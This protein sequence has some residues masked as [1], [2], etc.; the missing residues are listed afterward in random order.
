MMSE[1]IVGMRFGDSFSVYGDYDKS[2]VIM[3]MGL[4]FGFTG[5]VCC[6]IS[7]EVPFFLTLY[8]FVYVFKPSSQTIWSPCV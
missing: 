8:T 5:L 4:S 3:F 6:G 2:D 7:L 1:M